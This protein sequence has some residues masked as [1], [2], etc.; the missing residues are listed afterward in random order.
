MITAQRI[1]YKHID[2]VTGYLVEVP[3]TPP[4]S[5]FL[6]HKDK[7]GYCR[8]FSVNTGCWC[9]GDR[10]ESMAIYRTGQLFH[11][12]ALKKEYVLWWAAQCDLLTTYRAYVWARYET[13][14]YGCL[15]SPNNTPAHPKNQ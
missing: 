15:I 12:Y 13:Y 14:H 6:L 11:A 2:T 8:V 7:Y 10:V 3:N 1:D 5:T 4:G 9:L